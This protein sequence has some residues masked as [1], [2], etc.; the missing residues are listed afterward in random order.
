MSN[1]CNFDIN[2]VA[3]QIGNIFYEEPPII[4]LEKQIK[5]YLQKLDRDEMS[6][7]SENSKLIASMIYREAKDYEY[8]KLSDFFDTNKLEY[9]IKNINSESI[10]FDKSEASIDQLQNTKVATNYKDISETFI[11]N[12]YG[13]A[14]KVKKEAMQ[15]VRVALVDSLFITRNGED[16]GVVDSTPKLNQK[17]QQYQQFLLD[18]ILTYIQDLPNLSKQELEA[19]RMGKMYQDG[20]YTGILDILH[21]TL[22]RRLSPN[23]FSNADNL[24]SLYNTK[25]NSN[26]MQARQESKKILDA[27]NAYVFL[28]NLD[29]YIHLL[30]KDVIHIDGNYFNKFTRDDKYSISE[31]Q[32]KIYQT[33]RDGDPTVEEEIS[34]VVVNI[35]E[36]T[37]LYKDGLDVPN[38]GEY[39]T[40][41]QCNNIIA[42]IKSLSSNPIAQKIVF[43]E[44][45]NFPEEIK[46]FINGK[47]LS[48]V[49]DLIFINPRDIVPIVCKILT[50]KNFKNTYEDLLFKSNFSPE[51]LNVL[52]TV[53]D[54]LIGQL[55]KIVGNNPKIDYFGYITGLFNTVYENTTIQFRIDSRRILKPMQLTDQSVY[56]IYTKI[57][58]RINNV[59]NLI[60]EPRYKEIQRAA[61]VRVAT[62]KNGIITSIKCNI[63]GTE[64]TA[65]VYFNDKQ[66]VT[67]YNSTGQIVNSRCNIIGNT[68]AINFIDDV[69]RLGLID[70]NLLQG[71]VYRSNEIE[72]SKNLIN[73]VASVLA[74][75]YV[76]IE[77][78][79]ETKQKRKNIL[80]KIYGAEDDIPYDINLKIVDLTSKDSYYDEI[81]KVK[82]SL[83]GLTTSVQV[84]TSQQTGQ[85]RLSLSRLAGSYHSQWTAFMKNPNAAASHFTL[86]KPGVLQKIYNAVEYYNP[87]TQE[88]K[89]FT[90]LT[91][92]ELFHLSFMGGFLPALANLKGTERDISSNGIALFL[93]S[94]N[95]DKNFIDFGQTNLNTVVTL[96]N[97]AMQSLIELDKMERRSFIADELGK[98]YIKML[99]KIE[100][101][102][103]DEVT[104]PISEN[105][106]VL[107]EYEYQTIKV[108][109]LKAFQWEYLRKNR[110]GDF[111]FLAQFIRQTYPDFNGFDYINNFSA[112]NNWYNSQKD[113]FKQKFETPARFIK[114]QCRLY[115]QI[116]RTNPIALTDQ[117]HMVVDKKGN[118]GN[119][120]TLLAQIAKFKPDYLNTS[121]EY[122]EKFWKRQS[123]EI[124]RSFLT[125]KTVIQVNENYLSE[126]KIIDPVA[127]YIYTKI[128]NWI[129]PI[130]NNLIYARVTINGH[131]YNLS[132]LTDLY[133]I[134]DITTVIT[135]KDGTQTLGETI[136][137]F[138]HDDLNKIVDYIHDNGSIE[139]NPLI[140]Q[141]N[142]LDYLITQEWQNA[143]VGT[144][145]THP[146]G[147]GVVS[148]NVDTLRNGDIDINLDELLK[149][150]AVKYLA[151]HKRNV[152]WSA[153][154]HAFQLNTL[155]GIGSTY[156][157]SVIED[158]EELVHVIQSTN[159]KIKPYDGA[160][161]SIPLVGYLENNSLGGSTSQSMTKKPFCHFIDAQLGSGGIIKTA[162]FVITN[163]T[164]RN[165]FLDRL[166]MKKMSSGE[167][168][169]ENGVPIDIDITHDYNGNQIFYGDIYFERNGKYYKIVG[170]IIKEQTILLDNNSLDRKFTRKIAE[171]DRYT[172]EVIGNEISETLSINN[173]YDLWNFFG[174][175][176][177]REFVTNRLGRKKLDYSEQSNK[178]VAYA[179]NKVGTIK[180]KYKG[181]P[182]EGISSQK[183]VYQPLKYS[184]IHYLVTEGAIKQGAANINSKE[185]YFTPDNDLDFFKINLH[186]IGI[187]LDKEHHADNAQVSLMTQVISAC[188]AL[189]YTFDRA[190]GIYTML[191]RIA[192]IGCKDFFRTARQ[193]YNDE[194]KFKDFNNEVLKIIISNLARPNS[195]NFSEKIAYD[196]EQE[197]KESADKTFADA[198][199]P[200]SDNSIFN[201]ALSALTSYVTNAA[202]KVKIAGT[203][204]VLNPSHQRIRVFEDTNGN[205]RKLENFDN[206]D[207]DIEALQLEHYNNPIFIRDYNE[208]TQEWEVTDQ[209]V[210][211]EMGRD[212]IINFTDSF[213]EFVNSSRYYPGT[214]S[215][216]GIPITYTNNNP[217]GIVF[218]NDAIYIDIQTLKEKYNTFNINL[219]FD[220][221]VT[222]E[223]LNE[224][225][226]FNN[227]LD[228]LDEGDSIILANLVNQDVLHNSVL[229]DIVKKGGN[230]TLSP[231]Y[232]YLLK[233]FIKKGYIDYIAEYVEKG[234]DLGTYNVRFYDIEGKN[235]YQLWDLE[236]IKLG[237]ELV[238]IKDNPK[239]FFEWQ[240]INNTNFSSWNDAYKYYRNR[241]RLD[242]ETLSNS[243]ESKISQF[244]KI[245]ESNSEK[246]LDL[247]IKQ[248]LSLLEQEKVS[249][250][251][252]Y[253]SKVAYIEN[254]DSIRD[255]VKL[256]TGETITVDKQSL[257]VQ[258]YEIIMP[259]RFVKQFDLDQNQ[260]LNDIVN[261]KDFFIKQAIRNNQS[262]VNKELYDVILKNTNGEH[263]YILHVDR[264]DSRLRPDTSVFTI[265]KDGKTI[266]CDP[267][268]DEELYELLPNS[269]IYKDHLG[270]R[271]IVVNDIETIRE[272]IDQLSF[273]NISL[274][275][276]LSKYHDFTEELLNTL[277]ESTSRGTFIKDKIMNIKEGEDLVTSALAKFA[278][279]ESITLDNYT[280]LKE[281]H[282]LIQKGREKHTSFLKSL[283]VV[284]ARIPAQSMQSFMAMK[285][286]AFDNPDINNVYVSTLQIFLQ[287]SDFDIDSATIWTYDIPNNGILR[288]WSPYSRITSIEEANKSMELPIPTGIEVQIKESINKDRIKAFINKY[289][290]TFKYSSDGTFRILLTDKLKDFLATDT[291]LVPLENSTVEYDLLTELVREN[292]IPNTE[293]NIFNDIKKA[294]DK[295]NFYLD[296]IYSEKLLTIAKNYMMYQTY[297]ISSNPVNQLQGMQSVDS[298]TEPFKEKAKESDAIKNSLYRTSGNVFNKMQSIEETQEGKDCIAKS[299]SGIKGFFTLYQYNN[300]VLNGIKGDDLETSTKRQQRLI[301]K[302]GL[303]A[304]IRAKDLSTVTNEEVIALLTSVETEEDA[305]QALSALLGLSADNAKELIL[306]KLNAGV[307]MIGM[308]LYGISMGMPLQEISRLMMSKAA[309]TLR[310][311]VKGNIFSSE[312]GYSRPISSFY[313][314]EEFTLNNIINR[315][316]VS[317][318]LINTLKRA[319]QT[320]RIPQVD[321]EDKRNFFFRLIAKSSDINYIFSDLDSAVS[322]ISKY[323]NP[324]LSKKNLLQIYK[325]VD[326]IKTYAINYKNIVYKGDNNQQPD[327]IRL[328]NLARG[329]NEMARVG[330][331]A[332]LNTGIKGSLSEFLKKVSL[333]EDSLY[334]IFEEDKG[335]L[336]KSGPEIHK[337]DLQRF[338]LDNNYREE[339]I[340]TY[341]KYKYQHNLLDVI[342]K[343]PNLFKYVEALATIDKAMNSSFRYRS[344]KEKYYDYVKKFKV[345]D[346]QVYKGISTFVQ[347]ATIDEW[348]K[349]RNIIINIPTNSKYFTSDNV[350]AEE[351]LKQ[352]TEFPL[353]T[354]WGNNTFRMWMEQKVIPDLANGN[355]GNNEN[356]TEVA[357][358][359]FIK[360][361]QGDVRTN[362][363]LGN[364]SIVET[365]P[366]NMLPRSDSENNL[367]Q[368]YLDSFNQLAKYKYAGYNVVDLLAYYTMIAH[369]WKLSENSLMNIFSDQRGK[370]ALNDYFKFVS[371][372][373]KSSFTISMYTNIDKDIIPYI[374]AKEGEYTTRSTYA[375]GRNEDNVRVLKRKMS[376]EEINLQRDIDNSENQYVPSSGFI[377]VY[378]NQLNS[379]FYETGTVYD[380]DSKTAT[381]KHG[382]DDIQID[383]KNNSN[384]KLL[385]NGQVNNQINV[386]MEGKVPMPNIQ[387]IKNQLDELKNKSEECPS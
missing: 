73:T 25:N 24:N 142:E 303:L 167:Y 56:N 194:T 96:P 16:L 41:Q 293:I 260:N 375:V 319:A 78:L 347:E 34:D 130:N 15:E 317:K 12:A 105:P 342:D 178:L 259:K 80:K 198:D 66:T 376:K 305:V 184:D 156:N 2:I 87:N 143:G 112:F 326:A 18:R 39:L 240:L 325:L 213:K 249:K 222:S 10:N 307:D 356:D 294:I 286:V 119:S 46:N 202:I 163:N 166:L 360:N 145:A 207:K 168:I 285:V 230:I 355:L 71:L 134:P 297:K 170:P 327:Y 239:D 335:K 36:T 98:Y 354:K 9:L 104:V 33:W 367:F 20:K 199:F 299:A 169:D 292:I 129:N 122:G 271:I 158:I 37:P 197:I 341:D 237:N 311:I 55:Q 135:E 53:G 382:E 313:Y 165:S 238:K 266:V 262:R 172:R 246:K 352:T 231:D 35:I 287:G 118:I 337:I 107:N 23:F 132:S 362:T 58:E 210:K 366:I 19:I 111:N 152:S 291:L 123:T 157:V 377:S 374:V 101:T 322:K 50:D 323:K 254:L 148:M 248:N 224:Y 74:N 321:N 57:K 300:A 67:I 340:A 280:K 304:N 44:K 108:S 258:A 139:I 232:Y 190:T 191:N 30:W 29:T 228:P 283:D 211:L 84:K 320:D 3:D 264:F 164:M 68:E 27:Y 99:H 384:P 81:A 255:Q 11:H 247:W 256:I 225:Y 274:S 315:T 334:T 295:H 64:Y 153:Q 206:E 227:N 344:I 14:I 65:Q 136:L 160:T 333:I 365:L 121:S 26:N 176:N 205:I 217:K 102:S 47:S 187:Q 159:N 309:L 49:I 4:E 100:L 106:N 138:K 269:A 181:I 95:S 183:Q 42:A 302:D 373:D 308:Y 378:G 90:D 242:L 120:A 70:S 298:V 137:S 296:K 212:Y 236:S 345:K 51:Q 59:N 312:K 203:L 85:S 348:F 265:Q 245:A 257:D 144:F 371:D 149:T 278:K 209:S 189:G 60:N 350:L 195:T 43:N 5:D 250:L 359:K 343:V 289:K 89:E 218:T 61:N 128:P 353:G 277:S 62:S 234:R 288:L 155:E 357:N 273:S 146:K 270:N 115:N 17:I 113:K 173:N 272:Y 229:E 221:Y 363:I 208:D 127:Y 196:I 1:K 82:A 162:N 79:N 358:N 141:Y 318:Y 88:H 175:Y 86:L 52:Y 179:A 140:E 125:T 13:S 97:G 7:I 28:T 361:L 381:F 219:S 48:E 110:I 109:D 351:G 253:Y 192:E 364:P 251:P 94:V 150:E 151:Q 220:D 268:T 182:K 147:A 92:S 223:L 316:K 339:C 282:P 93:M 63:P 31:K 215:Y 370:G 349:F 263:F 186:Q 216:R 204:S 32:S 193:Y 379:N 116:H 369:G 330:Q 69:L 214:L 22:E 233:D 117:L 6:G 83:Q 226:A 54:K 76:S 171:V 45:S 310:D 329:A 200:L 368:D 201:K 133:N 244:I 331:V 124:L 114:E 386:I 21:G 180:E 188:A 336:A 261:D 387:S 252:D 75:Q 314:I 281:W 235:R 276:N 385:I 40:F 154:M 275:Q 301:G 8:D 77:V 243:T 284:A 174:G 372:L 161:Y 338:V 346:E 185:K 91:S 380:I 267:N 328:K 332:S 306:Y 38:P 241:I 72:V 279:W 383:W 290:D 126:R 177:S 324:P 131:T 103:N